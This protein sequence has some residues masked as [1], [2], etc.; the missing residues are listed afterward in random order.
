MPWRV[1]ASAQAERAPIGKGSL[2]R[3]GARESLLSTGMETTLGSNKSP[4]IGYCSPPLDLH[5][6]Y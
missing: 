2:N 5:R 6:E 4:Q 3:R 1:N